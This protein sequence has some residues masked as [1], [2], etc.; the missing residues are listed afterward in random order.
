MQLVKDYLS[1]S[2]MTIM[3]LAALSIIIIVNR[4]NQIKGIGC[5][6]IVMILT[7]TISMLD[8]LELWCDLTGRPVWI[9]SIL[10]G[11]Y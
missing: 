6:I 1:S 4:K 11:R 9:D 5:V 8:H 3:L 2:Y 10:C 7:F